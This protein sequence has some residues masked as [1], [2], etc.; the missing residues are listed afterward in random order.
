MSYFA[1][2]KPT[3]GKSFEVRHCH[4]NLWSLPGV[5]GRKIYFDVGVHFV[6]LENNVKK[7]DVALPLVA[8]SLIDISTPLRDRVTS[9]L[10]FRTESSQGRISFGAAKDV[11]ISQVNEE[12]CKAGT[13]KESDRSLWHVSIPEVLQGDQRYFRIRFPVQH[14][15]RMW[16]KKRH[17]LLNYGAL[18]DF[19]VA[20]TREA[21]GD[22]EWDSVR[23]RI[24]P[25]QD[26]Y[27][28]VIAPLTL[29]MQSA[30]PPLYTSRIL[31]G[32]SWE[33]YLNRKTRGERMVIYQW[34]KNYPATTPPRPEIDVS[35]PY[36]VFLDLSREVISVSVP[37]A[38]QSTVVT[39]VIIGGIGLLIWWAFSFVDIAGLKT[40]WAKVVA[41]VTVT[42]I[43]GWIVSKVGLARKIIRGISGLVRKIDDWRYAR[44]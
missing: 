19:R 21:P 5:L 42:G 13:K 11:E 39:I 35:N 41:G 34:N 15:G 14:C 10:I 23:D 40:A 28:F 16:N 25:I 7:F 36:R 2:V 18:L 29:Q 3:D 4:I 24:V 27:V 32:D 17:M 22:P 12:D 44:G 33:T 37:A 31:E 1:L 30:S 38:I 26:L 43:I 8:D 6:A 20:D 9:Q